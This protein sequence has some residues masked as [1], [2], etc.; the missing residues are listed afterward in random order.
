MFETI[1]Y[2]LTIGAILYFFSI[3]LSLTFGTMH[4]INFAHGMVYALGVYVFIAILRIVDSFGLSLVLAVAALVPVAWLIERFVIR[5]LYGASL[6]YAMIATYALLLMGTDL[7]KLIWGGIPQPVSDPIGRSWADGWSAGKADRICSIRLA[8]RD[9]RR[10][11]RTVK[12]EEPMYRIQHLML[13]RCGNGAVNGIDQL[14]DIAGPGIGLQ[15]LE[16]FRRNAFF[17]H[18]QGPLV[19]LQNQPVAVVVRAGKRAF[20][21]PKEHAFNQVFRECGTIE[22]H[23]RTR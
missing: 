11:L 20:A 2:G 9:I 19:C 7:I 10:A 4:I 3:G 17:I 14:A 1:L 22:H 6:D 15:G 8:G 13:L 23:E 12:H 21:V 18:E 5:R 16:K